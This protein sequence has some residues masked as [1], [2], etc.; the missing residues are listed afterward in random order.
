VPLR[1][2]YLRFSAASHLHGAPSTTLKF[3]LSNEG[4]DDLTHIVVRISIVAKP[5]GA[6]VSNRLAGPYTL[7]GQN[8]VLRPGQTLNFEMTLKNLSAN[9]GCVA[10]VNVLSAQPIPATG[11]PPSLVPPSPRTP[12]QPPADRVL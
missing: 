6:G 3:G 1:V 4:E 8:V 9:C 2:R 10:H 5:V 12:D 7:K 11:T